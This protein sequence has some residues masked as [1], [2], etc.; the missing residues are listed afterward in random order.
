MKVFHTATHALHNPPCEIYTAE[1]QVSY[2][3]SPLRVESI[4]SALEPAAFEI[5]E[6]PDSGLAPIL[7][8]HSPAYLEYLRTA[9]LR[10][11][12]FSPVREMAFIPCT[13]AFEEQVIAG[14][15]LP[16]RNGFFMTDDAV[17]VTGG[18][19][20]AA[21]AAAHCALAAADSVREAPGKPA[22]ALCRPPGHHAGRETCGGYCFLNNAAIAARR[23]ARH[24]RVAILDIDYHAGNGTQDIFYESDEV[25]TVSIHADPDEAYPR[26]AGFP[27][28]TGSGPGAGLH[29]NFP[30]PPGTG[31]A[32]YLETLARA[33]DCIGAFDPARL[34]VSAGM[35]I[36]E[37]D[38]LGDFRIS[39]DGIAAIGRRIA[40]TRLP[41][42]IVLEGG[43][44]IAELGLNIS[45]LLSGWQ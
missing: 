40:A 38:P 39:R 16:E 26:F 21:L 22:F 31:D 14:A 8:V 32:P 10:W 15:A 3:E 25:L 23:L 35:D 9:Y 33:L 18:T 41:A 17:P 28:E 36:Y 43:Y 1:E 11:E 24:G 4:L 42:A 2:D 20:A 29:K 13:P 30:L 6:P 44:N 37:H 7:D 19:Y 45:A 27:D 5:L 34:V 12:P